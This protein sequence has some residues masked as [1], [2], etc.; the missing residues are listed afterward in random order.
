MTIKAVFEVWNRGPFHWVKLTSCMITFLL[1]IYFWKVRKVWVVLN[2]KVSFHLSSRCFGSHLN[3]KRCLWFISSKIQCLHKAGKKFSVQ[4]SNILME[5]R[6]KKWFFIKRCTYRAVKF[7]I[8]IST[9]GAT[10]ILL[11][12]LTLMH[13]IMRIQE[14]SILALAQLAE[15]AQ[16]HLFENRTCLAFLKDFRIFTQ[17]KKAVNILLSYKSGSIATLQPR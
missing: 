2:L 9:S 1:Y 13:Y 6:V 11:P 12:Q 4:I 14:M 16:L 17:R 15:F 7:L 10:W 3:C 8:Q 5:K